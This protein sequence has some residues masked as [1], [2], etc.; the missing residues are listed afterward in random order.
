MGFLFPSFLWGL[1]A[2][3][4]PIAIHIFNFR[5]TKKVYFT[6]VAFLKAV[7]TK[8][9]SV[10]QVKHWLVLAA[11]VLAIICLALAFAQP[12]LPAKNNFAVDRKG[13]T[14]LYLDNS[15]SMESEL[16][17][18]RYLD[19]A[20][21]RLSEL[22]GLFRNATSL[23]LVTNDFSA[24][25]QGLYASEKLRDRLTTIGLSNTPR[26]FE[27]VYKRQENLMARHQHPG[28]N[29]L[30]WF[31]DFQK[32]TSG[33][34][35]GLKTD[36][37]NQLF[38]VPVQAAAEKNVFVDSAWL[39]TPFIRELQNNILFVKVSNSGSEA[40]RNVVLKLNL[41][42]T[43]A[44]TA[45]VN[46]PAN[47]SATA[48]FNFNLKGKGYKKG[49][50]TFDDFPVTFDNNYYFV[51]NASPL[52]RVLHIYGQKSTGNYIENVYANDSL[53]SLQS[54]SANNVDPGLIKKTDL[55]VLEGV[56]A[57]SGSLP[58][59][60]QELIRNGGSITVIPP[61][62][63]NT[64]SYNGFL[65]RLGVNGLAATQNGD[66]A[67]VAFAAPDRN[68][69]FFSDVFEESVRQELNL[70]LP[71]ASPVWSWANAG[72]MVLALRNGQ[73]YLNQ[74]TSGTGKLYLFAAPLNPEYGNIAQHAIF[75]PIMYKIAAS[76]VRAQRTSFKFDENPIS[77]NVEKA[78]PNTVY[79][80]RR[81]KTEVI[82]VQRIAGNQLL[83]EIPQG[84]Q[85]G[86]G[87][88]A[89]Y[90]EL[91][92]DNKVEQIIALNHNNAES[93]LQYYSP[94]EL[95]TIFAGQKNIQVFDRIDDDA[96]STAF[97]QQNMGT[98]LWKYFLY[99]ALFFLLVEIALIRFLK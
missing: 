8:T 53:F 72:Q 46:V 58:Q 23:Q 52:I 25:E 77:L 66:P 6:N 69:P 41:D 13:I 61:A 18:K 71:S 80:L 75:V 84:D 10:R 26:T 11:R 51:L 93:K 45:S 37:T 33:N 17:N 81:N 91:L 98:N 59:D 40:A 36:T 85:L 48:K 29:Q 43:Q 34:L 49:Q 89:G 92:K 7:E 99:A 83:L 1:L 63:P 16:N 9:R 47:G 35:S 21:A 54:Y 90:F 86:E 62:A 31:S 55:V 60:L 74:V 50:I 30:F 44:S 42:N 22:L 70:N 2:V 65:A 28:K 32:S 39:N 38:L 27:Q 88:D 14:S 4:V 94:D 78:Q 67:P 19:I 56:T 73:T 20:T 12:F 57:L 87:L 76:S 96:F 82:P 79:K 5:R 97:Q 95:R 64:E 3:S 68:N 15:L 24:Q